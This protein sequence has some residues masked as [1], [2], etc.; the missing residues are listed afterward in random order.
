MISIPK[1]LQHYRGNKGHAKAY[2]TI[3]N[4]IPPHKV[5]IEPY[6]GSAGVYRHLAPCERVI[7]NDI[8]PTVISS[9]MDHQQ[10]NMQVSQQPSV[11]LLSSLSPGDTDTFIYL[12]PPYPISSRLSKAEIYNFEMTDN[13]HIQL[14]TTL[15]AMD[16]LCMVSTY[17]NDIYNEMLNT[18]TLVEFKTNV[19]GTV[20]TEQLYM[21]YRSPTVLHD[22]RHL[23]KDCWDRQRIKRKLE[24]LQSKL[25]A[26]EPKERNALIQMIQ[27]IP[28]GPS[29]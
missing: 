8:D 24:R 29:S 3:I 19:H 14:L 12:D 18:W 26:L 13:D 27:S 20:V 17:P 23:G 11:Q 7:L 15:L 5:Y 16:C 21:N 1:G 22:Y 6:A 28:T 10:P 4:H 2:Q 9:W 25:T